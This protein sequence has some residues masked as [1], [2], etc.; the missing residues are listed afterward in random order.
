MRRVNR[1]LGKGNH[2]VASVRLIRRKQDVFCVTSE[3]TG[4]FALSCGIIAKNCGLMVNVTTL[5]P[6][7]EGV[8]TLE[9]ANSGGLPVKI[10]AME[11]IAKVR[12]FRIDGELGCDYAQKG[13]VYNFQKGVTA[14]IVNKGGQP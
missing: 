12:F 7:W 9:I 6:S 1:S 11:G 3:D 2:T 13:G 4:N 5:E 14:A 10:Y 8:L